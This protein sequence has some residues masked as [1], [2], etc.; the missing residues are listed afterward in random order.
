MTILSS[1]A[2]PGPDDYAV[3]PTAEQLINEHVD[4]L[5]AGSMSENTRNDA[6]R[7][8][9]AADRYLVKVGSPRGLLTAATEELVSWLAN[10]TW[11]AQTKATYRQHLRRF[12]HW[13][14]ELGHLDWDPSTT[15]K[16]P[17]VPQGRPRPATRDQ[18]VI[19]TTR[20]EMPFLL[21][22]RLAAYQGLRCIEIARLRREHVTRTETEVWGK[23][24]THEVVPTHPRVWELVCGRT[25]G[26]LVT[27]RRGWPV[28]DEW[29]SHE[30][31]KALH[32]AG[33]PI[34]M[35]QLRHYFATEL[36]RRTGNMELVRRLMRHKSM[37]STQIYTLVRFDE[38][39]AA[40]DQL[41]DLGQ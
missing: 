17:R 3:I 23:G 30:G 12:Y 34:T 7:T 9:R 14:V 21:A 40:V 5:S 25:D 15:L 32:R 27:R 33:A 29:M 26:P 20:L 39:A 8:L 19:A 18:A 36:L 1:T 24:D 31:K 11:T 4:Y 41:P 2:T 13:A 38:L 28:S 35:H 6:G 10:D 22:G 37:T 16:R